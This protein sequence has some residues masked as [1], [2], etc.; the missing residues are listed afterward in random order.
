MPSP[1]QST[2]SSC[3]TKVPSSFSS[4]GDNRKRLWGLSN[5][6]AGRILFLL[7]LAAV[8]AALGFLANKFLTEA[9]T[10]LAE[11]QFESIADRALDAALGITLRE[12]L[13]T[14]TMASIASSL[15][16]DAA[17]WPNVRVPWYETISSNLIE[18]SSGRA[19]GLC[20]L[21]TPAQLESFEEHVYESVVPVGAA[22]SSFGKGVYGVDRSLNTTDN[23]YHETDGSTAWSSPN[24]IFAPL[25]QHSKGSKFPG[26]MQNIHHDPTRGKA[27]DDLIKCSASRTV[28][29]GDENQMRECGVITDMVF[30]RSQVLDNLSKLCAGRTVDGGDESPTRDCASVAG[31]RLFGPGDTEPTAFILQPIYP[32]NDNIEVR[33]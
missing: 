30:I 32:A 3:L 20:P 11:R 7:C 17:S 10:D 26:L 19:M 31:D 29:D 15:F 5:V 21:V 33:T 13:G 6:W 2:S 4:P 27:I 14:V 1:N 12:R 23:R 16:P 24:R 25:L 8:A 18:T 9:E 28:D 22:I